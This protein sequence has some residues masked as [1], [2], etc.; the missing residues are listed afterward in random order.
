MRIN[1]R[2]RRMKKHLDLSPLIDIVFLL[3]IFFMLSS[4][5]ILQ[6]GIHVDLPRALSS[7]KLNQRDHALITI[8]PNGNVYFNDNILSIDHLLKV[9]LDSHNPSVII[10]ADGR[11]ALSHVVQVWDICRRAGISSISIA[12]HQTKT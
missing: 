8:T 2:S 9:L 1:R 12:A 3:L 4:S 7:E 5:F 6:P 11:V 10:Q